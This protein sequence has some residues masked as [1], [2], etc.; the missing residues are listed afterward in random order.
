MAPKKLNRM[1]ADLKSMR[2]ELLA[3]KERET[4]DSNG[5]GD[6][7]FQKLQLTKL[8]DEVRKRTLL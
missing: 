1:I 2:D 4:I 8:L 7:E 6:F 5:G 3:E